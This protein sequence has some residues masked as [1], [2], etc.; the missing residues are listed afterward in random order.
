MSFVRARAR[1]T[2]PP[3][4]PR[5]APM[6][7]LIV[8]ALLI[9]PA[10][11][12]MAA[13]IASP[14]LIDIGPQDLASALAAW[15]RQ[16]GLKLRTTATAS[17][18]AGQKAPAVQG[19]MLPRDALGRLL[20]TSGL[21]LRAEADPD[22]TWVLTDA[23]HAS[24]TQLPTVTVTARRS[25]EQA[26]NVPFS[27]SVVGGEE[28]EQ[29]RLHT[30]EDAL[31]SAPGVDVS[32]F[33]GFNDTNVRMRGVGSLFQISA[34][35]SS[36]VLNVDGVPLSSLKSS[37]GTMDV[38]RVEVLK[39]PQGTLFGRNSEGGAI[40]ITTRRPTRTL[41]G[42]VRGEV[43]QEGQRLAEAAVSGPLSET[44][45]ARIALRSAGSDSTVINSQDGKPLLKAR[46]T[47]VRASLLWQPS[48]GT[49]ALLVSERQDQEGKVGLSV[50][51]PYS[52]PPK[53]ST[54]PGLQN[55]DN[56]QDRHSLEI[57]HDLVSSRISSLTSYTPGRS[58][59]L[60]CYD[61][62]LSNAVFG[63]PV[64][65]CH[66][67]SANE[68]TWN[69]DLRWSSLPNAPV[70]WVAGLNAANTQRDYDDAIPSAGNTA[71][72]HYVTRSQ[73]A[74]G[75]VT[76]P[77]T[78]AFKLTGGLRH[79]R[80]RKTYSGEFRN[81][82]APTSTDRRQ[83]D[84]GYTTGRVALLYALTPRTNLYAVVARGYKSGGFTDYTSQ[85]ADGEPL[86]PAKV[87]SFEFGAKTESADRRFALN[88]ALFQNRAKDDHLLGYDVATFATRGLNTDTKTQGAEVE[89]S[90]RVGNGWSLSGGFNITDA[91]ITRDV[92]G[93][94]GGDV[95]S[96]NRVPD[97]ARFGALA[98][99]AWRTALPG[100]WGLSSPALDT[101]MTWRHVGKRL[102]DPQNHIEL[103]A[104]DKLDL[105]VGVTSGAAEFYLWVDNL[106]DKRHELYAYYYAPGVSAGMVSRGRTA[107]LGA[108][109]SF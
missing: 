63:A 32:S 65:V 13:T 26:R 101:S 36:V 45:S 55:A 99:V 27:V 44:F 54:A 3:S 91:K 83:L 66:D 6:A 20:A 71:F 78:E 2:P 18:L 61:R 87:N 103:A 4:S 34:E 7:A 58:H 92:T 37:L 15:Q 60:G 56:A 106:T 47:G 42:F 86:K 105:R 62:D 80:E 85:I 100:F 51:R 1:H 97:V 22:G 96:G 48:A 53:Q 94:S 39:G 107:G 77:L 67:V 17:I 16:T 73:A 31:R 108:S 14:V 84:D 88:A 76:Y 59:S 75:E 89:A 9:G 25:S 38:D 93:V 8:L 90:W 43:G 98:K 109:L 52:E 102:N 64:E 82:A 57:N 95:T 28:L 104:Y 10:P 68:K 50:L 79:T 35:D 21:T 33:G 11:G 23:N 30:L 12:A 29:R 74:Y 49:S 72:R 40:N 19:A 24:D 69:Q 41:E 5:L 81:P 70:F 46:E